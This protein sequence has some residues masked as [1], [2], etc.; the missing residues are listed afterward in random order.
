MDLIV[1]HLARDS[2]STCVFAEDYNSCIKASGSFA[3]VAGDE[4]HVLAVFL[5]KGPCA[6]EI[7]TSL[8]E[9]LNCR[10]VGWYDASPG[11]IT[12]LVQYLTCPLCP[13][14]NFSRSID[15]QVARAS[16][17]SDDILKH[18]RADQSKDEPARKPRVRT[19]KPVHP[20]SE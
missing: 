11:E 2:F 5:K 14:N 7:H 20:L 1:G 13:A 18:A 9:R 19:R 8:Q 10:T 6:K 15:N 3:S 12:D 17:Q 4:I 16:T